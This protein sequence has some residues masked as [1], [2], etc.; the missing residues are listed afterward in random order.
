MLCV[1][2]SS[3]PLLKKDDVKLEKVQKMATMKIHNIEYFK[4]KTF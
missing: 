2:H 4:K 1:M 3:L